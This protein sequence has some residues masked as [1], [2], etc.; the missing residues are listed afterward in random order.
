MRHFQGVDTLKK[1][2]GFFAAFKTGFLSHFWIPACA[3]K[4]A[5]KFET[6]I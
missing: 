6:A 5:F 2:F 3:G 4:T 1:W